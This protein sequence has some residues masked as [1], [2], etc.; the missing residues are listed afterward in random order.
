MDSVGALGRSK[1]SRLLLRNACAPISLVDKM[2]DSWS[3]GWQTL[4]SQSIRV[5]IA[6]TFV[7]LLFILPETA[8]IVALECETRTRARRWNLKLVDY[9]FPE[10]V[11]GDTLKSS[12]QDGGLEELA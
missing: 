1:A 4:W 2:G 10:L 7:K 8:R 5:N 6:L 11:R 12:S 9:L 3:Q